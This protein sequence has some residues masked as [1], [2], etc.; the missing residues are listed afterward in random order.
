MSSKILKENQN[1]NRNC[2]VTLKSVSHVSFSPQ[3]FS[4]RAKIQS[5]HYS[6]E[7]GVLAHFCSGWKVRIP[8]TLF[9]GKHLC[10]K[11]SSKASALEFLQ[12]KPPDP[13]LA[14]PSWATVS[15]WCLSWPWPPC[16]S[17]GR[18]R[19]QGHHSFLPTPSGPCAGASDISGLN[20]KWSFGVS[21]DKAF[22]SANAEQ[23]PGRELKA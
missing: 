9:S 11:V 3:S 12:Q 15:P 19:L 22:C 14:F 17:P 16:G 8:V 21:A 4:H 1:T 20:A 6:A 10:K 2:P 7:P 18:G 13:T 23:M 5:R